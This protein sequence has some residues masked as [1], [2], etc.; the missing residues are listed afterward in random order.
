MSFVSCINIL[1]YS[2]VFACCKVNSTAV[3]NSCFCSSALYCTTICSCISFET[4]VI[5]TCWNIQ[6]SEVNN[7]FSISYCFAITIVVSQCNFLS[8]CIVFVYVFSTICY[9]TFSFSATSFNCCRSDMQFRRFQC[10]CSRFKIS[11]V[12]CSEWIISSSSIK[13]SQECITSRCTS[14]VDSRTNIVYDGIATSSVTSCIL[15]GYDNI[16][17]RN[18]VTRRTINVSCESTIWTF[19]Y[20]STISFS[21]NCWSYS[22][23]S[24]SFLACCS[25]RC[26]RNSYIVTSFYNSTKF[27]NFF[28]TIIIDIGKI[29]F[30]NAFNNSIFTCYYSTVTICIS[31]S[32]VT[33]SIYC[34][35]I[36][37]SC[38]RD[39]TF[40]SFYSM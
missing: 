34:I 40:S 22:I 23:Y 26:F 37:S 28:L 18:I 11:Y 27:S 21:V 35:F 13:V 4:V 6:V 7:S 15:E 38:R 9:A 29:L 20:F 31:H 36:T 19:N 12:N 30:S 2:Q 33:I 39:M 14:F 10:I 8:S 16:T 32:N 24:V 17:C 25:I 3:F 5:A 1:F